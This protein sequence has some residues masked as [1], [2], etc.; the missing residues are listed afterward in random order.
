MNKLKI[1]MQHDESDCAAACLR[2]ILGFFGKDVSIRK[3]RLNAMTD[4]QGTSGLGIAMCAKKNGLTCKAFTAPDK[5]MIFDIP[6]PAIFHIR[7]KSMEHYVVLSKVTNDSVTIFDPAEGVQKMKVEEFF[8]LWTGIFFL[9]KP[10]DDFVKSKD[11]DSPFLKFFAVLKNH[12]QLLSKIIVSSLLLCSF[13]IFISFYFRFLIDEVLYSEVKSTL[14]LCSIC[15]LIVLLFQG[16]LSYCRNQLVL[17]LG[18]KIDLSLI[19][20]FFNHLLRLPLSFFT[21]RKTGEI[22][23]RVRDTEIIRRTISSTTVS[24]LIDSIMI[25]FGSF[26][27]FKM[28]S[29]LLYV[30]II[31]VLISSLIVWLCA[32]PFKRLIR[33]R[34]FAEANKNA[35][36]YETINGIATIKALSTENNAFRRN[37]ILCVNSTDASIK[38]ESFGNLNSALQGFISS[39]GTLLIYWIGSYKIFNGG[40]SLGQLISFTTLSGFFLGPLS[41]LLTMQP[42]LQEAIVAA[43][44]LS[45]VM[46]MEE[47]M[48]EENYYEDVEPLKNNFEFKDVSFAYGARKKAVENINLTIK[49][50]EKIAIVGASGSGKSTLLKLLMKFYKSESGT[51]LMDGKDINSLKTDDYRNMIGYVPQ[52]SLLFSGSIA[53]NI[54]W[55]ME[56]F[57]PQMIYQAAEEAQALNFILNLP[58]KFKTI[59]GENGATLSGG[60]RQ[61]IALARILMRNPEI[62]ILD[63]ATASL[64]SLSEKAIM[65]VVNSM[66]ERTIIIVAHRL[67]TIKECDRIYVMNNGRIMEYGKHSEL[68][69][70]KGEYKKLW[71]AQYEK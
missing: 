40:M 25:V 52:E 67:S 15:Y 19:C 34:A 26:F 62:I 44:R 13:G 43:E 33:K 27:L 47:E 21:S 49:K 30:S 1:Q 46:D 11:E 64:D 59:V 14:N 45:D 23:S 65:S 29:S 61:R 2:M 3:L 17:Y 5:S 35:S 60:E 48:T 57:T 12:K 10:K 56:N 37:E 7:N 69:K 71:G 31:P 63:E 38:L 54:A 9:C 36:M 68:L 39:L 53:E 70:A 51:I 22:L 55:G 24:V 58:E 6:L 20:E 32:K 4:T 50:G 16:F 28:G 18:T 41:R 66:K 8:A 42:H